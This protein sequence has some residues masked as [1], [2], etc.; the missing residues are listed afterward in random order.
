MSL[1]ILIFS[2]FLRINVFTAPLALA[3][4]APPLSPVQAMI[5]TVENHNA[6][7]TALKA[8]VTLQ[9][10]AGDKTLAA[11]SG[12]LTY[13]R[14]D[15]KLLLQCF[16]PE[17][18]MVFAFKTDDRRFELYLPGKKAAFRGN[19]FEL[20]DSPDI[21]SH[22]KPL[23]LY[24]AL[25][26]KSIPADKTI[27]QKWTG[28]LFFLN[29]SDENR[30]VPHLARRMLVTKDGQVQEEVYYNDDGKTDVIIQRLKFKNFN[31]VDGTGDN[32]PYPGKI[33]ISS[34]I[35]GLKTMIDFNQIQFF[36]LLENQNWDLSVP[37]DIERIEIADEAIRQ[38]QSKDRDAQTK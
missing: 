24:R 3:A 28:G 1:I 22:L 20:E 25:K 15:E 11:C 18:K 27:L 37:P 14:L 32:I 17:Q 4:G 30:G 12:D 5:R 35:G 13:Q 10:M 2:L 16:N 9:F 23:D 8:K 7:W 21:E 38:N 6:G 26:P 31:F 36:A 33:L 29:I 34:A 19:I